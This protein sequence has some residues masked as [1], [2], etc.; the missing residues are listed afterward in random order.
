[1]SAKSKSK[2]RSRS[3]KKARGTK[4][5]SPSPKKHKTAKSRSRSRSRDEPGLD[6]LLNAFGTTK[7][8]ALDTLIVELKKGPESQIVKNFWDGVV[9]GV[10]YAAAQGQCK[11]LAVVGATTV[12]KSKITA[13]GGEIEVC[14]AYTDTASPPSC[15]PFGLCIGPGNIASFSKEM[16]SNL[17]KAKTLVDI[18]QGK[19]VLSICM[20][21]HKS[22][23][24]LFGFAPVAF[25][26]NITLKPSEAKKVE[27]YRTEMKALYHKMIH[28]NKTRYIELNCAATVPVVTNNNSVEASPYPNPA[29]VGETDEAVEKSRGNSL[30]PMGLL[31]A[32]MLLRS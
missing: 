11:S 29:K 19:I 32:S 3:P 2:G 20:C 14:G 1:M 28:D 16:E 30:S 27:E 10:G 26:D 23:K 22:D 25:H 21:E 8:A 18:S 17:Q 15:S 6:Q 13:L 5:R 9:N 4:D 24:A 7:Q 12:M 31:L